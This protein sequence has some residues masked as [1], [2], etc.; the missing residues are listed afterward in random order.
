MK[1]LK[2]IYVSYNCDWFDVSFLFCEWV[3]MIHDSV[4]AWGHW[5]EEAEDPSISWK[6]AEDRSSKHFRGRFFAKTY[7]LRP[8]CVLIAQSIR[9]RALSGAKKN[10]QNDD[11]PL[12]FSFFSFLSIFLSF[13]NVSARSRESPLWQRSIVRLRRSM[14]NSRF[15][16]K[17]TPRDNDDR[18]L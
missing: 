7:F 14:Q 18:K 13:W 3:L 12:F 2:S 4:F 11:S 1:F 9:A 15:C 17:R 8:V 10:S 16:D 5:K 6:R